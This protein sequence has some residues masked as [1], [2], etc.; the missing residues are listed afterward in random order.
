MERDTNFFF[1]GKTRM[2]ATVK[3]YWEN[4]NSSGM[5]MTISKNIFMFA[6]ERKKK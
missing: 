6:K 2:L 1:D 5:E 3:R 4:F